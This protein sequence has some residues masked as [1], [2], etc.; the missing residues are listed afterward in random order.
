MSNSPVNFLGMALGA[1]AAI[2]GGKRNKGRRAKMKKRVG[3]LEN[4]VQGLLSSQNAGP[5]A[6][7]VTQ[8]IGNASQT[9]LGAVPSATGNMQDGLQLNDNAPGALGAIGGGFQSGAQTAGAGMF[10]SPIPGSFDRSM[11]QPGVPGEEE[12]TY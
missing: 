3:K 7:P 11:Q 4:Q 8:E 12:D 1:A 2:R 5:T 9:N 6:T 10:G